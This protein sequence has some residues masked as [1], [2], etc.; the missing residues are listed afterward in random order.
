M[1]EKETHIVTMKVGTLVGGQFVAR[2]ESVEVP[3]DRA[4]RFIQQGTALAGKV[5]LPPEPESG[6]KETATNKPAAEQRK[7]A[8]EKK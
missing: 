6:E 3:V 7:K 5:D 2:G 8:T 4:K 1:T